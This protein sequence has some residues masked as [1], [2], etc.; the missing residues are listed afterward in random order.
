MK[1]LEAKTFLLLTILLT[2]SCSE[3][4]T[5]MVGDPSSRAQVPP[6]LV[7]ASDRAVDNGKKHLRK[8]N[9]DKAIKE[10]NKA[11]DKDPRNFEALYWLGVAEGMCGHYSRAYDRFLLAFK[12][13]PDKGWQARVYATI[14]LTLLYMGK[15]DEAITYFERARIIDPKNEIVIAF[16]DWEE[17]ELNKGKGHKKPKIKKKPKDREGFEITLKWLD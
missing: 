17:Q 13:S 7:V 2:F 9:C 4:T 6:G 10:F 8:G 15:D 14:G 1:Q 5:V 11:L 3:K 16:Y 12:Y